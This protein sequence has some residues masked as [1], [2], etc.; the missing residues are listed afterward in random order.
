MS[1]IDSQSDFDVEGMGVVISSGEVIQGTLLV[2][3]KYRSF[4]MID[5]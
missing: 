2:I 5:L 4:K 3:I 1:L